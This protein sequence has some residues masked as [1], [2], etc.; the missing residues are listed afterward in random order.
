M[1]KVED[2]YR[3]VLEASTLGVLLVESGRI[4]YANTVALNLLGSDSLEEIGGSPLLH[5]IPEPQ[6]QS[7]YQFLTEPS[8]DGFVSGSAQSLFRLDGTLL[9][10]VVVSVRFLRAG[11][12]A[13][14]ILFREQREH[15]LAQRLGDDLFHQYQA[16]L[17]SSLD[18]IHLVDTQGNL[19]EANPAFCQMLGYSPEE[20]S[21]LKVFDWDLQITLSSLANRLASQS[22][23]GEILETQFRR[24]GGEVIDVELSVSSLT[25]G[26]QRYLCGVARDVTGRKRAEEERQREQ[27]VLSLGTLAGGISHDFNNILQGLGGNV[28]MAQVALSQGD[29]MLT[30][31]RLAKTRQ[32]FERAKTLTHQLL[33]FA[34][35]GKPAHQPTNLG[36][37]L[38]EWVDLALVGADLTTR[39]EVA[40]DLW[41]VDCDANQIGQVVHNLLVNARQAS[42]ENGAVFV[43]AYNT[44]KGGP[45]VVIEVGDEGL[46]IRPEVIRRV[47]DPY[48]TTKRDGT[49][50][51][52]AV[53]ISIVRQHGGRIS[54]ANRA[55]G[56]AVFSVFLPKSVRKA[57]EPILASNPLT[58]SSRGG[59]AIVLDDDPGVREVA[60]QMLRSLGFAVKECDRGEDVLEFYLGSVHNGSPIDF[61][62]MD[63]QVSGGMGGIPTMQKLRNLGSRGQIVLMSGF[64]S[65]LFD[66][67][68]PR[69]ETVD[70]LAKPF[71]REDL[72]AVLR[73]A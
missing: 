38:P 45:Q 37:L 68:D 69:G 26:G 6:K 39:I 4:V 44:T 54:A 12:H 20:I 61:F 13:V 46:G 62:L 23:A 40:P 50:L 63:K 24:K 10:V 64:F 55:S 1:I 18:G 52:L 42:P 33:T 30:K 47:F 51:G 48:F 60:S 59:R 53:S 16:V 5:R 17:K 70:Y 28:E 57:S 49:G 58:P 14:Q 7:V 3:E 25:L 27:R 11:S 66:F 41:E 36:Q 15:Q 72:E 8:K 21:R 43:R 2:A 22:E 32:G 29:L 19:I 34:K 67:L 65:D 31:E 71:S 9:E 56:G 73:R 35:G